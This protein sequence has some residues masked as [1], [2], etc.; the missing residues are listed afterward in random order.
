MAT[1]DFNALTRMA[2][3]AGF[4]TEKL[5]SGEYTA[6][7]KAANYTTKSN[8]KSQ[9]GFMFRVVAGPAQ[10]QSIWKNINVPNPATQTDPEKL[11]R[12][13]SFFIRD[14][15]ALGVRQDLAGTDPDA[16]AK[17]I[18]GRQFTIK[19]SRTRPKGNGEFWEDVDV[20]S[21]V[22]AASA[23]AAVAPAPVQQSFPTTDAPAPAW[24]N[25][26]I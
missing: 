14:L 26:P 1:I 25:R 24:Q 8:G 16:A 23:P 12:A 22:N 10:G 11:A 19:V 17:E 3:E 5:E 20:K 21:A 7:V 6:E 2:E 15:N 9:F 4:S 13:A 18:I